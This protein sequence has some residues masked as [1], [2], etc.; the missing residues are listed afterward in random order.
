MKIFSGLEFVGLAEVLKSIGVVVMST[1][2][3]FGLACSARSP[4]AV[5]RMYAVKQRSGKPGTIIAASF[6]QLVDLGF[7]SVV[8][9]KANEMFWPAPVSVVLDA[10]DEL[11][12][13]HMGKKSLAVRVPEPKWLRDLLVVTGPLATTSANL[14]GEPTAKTI[15]EA[16]EIFGD[17]VDFYFD[18]GT[19]NEAKPS[20]IFKIS[21][22]GTIETIRS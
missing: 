5:S 4:E 2:T 10:P 1:D 3:V 18:N 12:Y 20:K 21:V 13:L 16:K 8:T 6:R 19:S 7:D 22:D 9:S 17:K 15:D 11:E 14:P